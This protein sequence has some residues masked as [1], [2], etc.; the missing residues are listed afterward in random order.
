MKH[1]KKSKIREW[2][3]ITFNAVFALLT[4]SIVIIFYK[5]IMITSVLLLI[6][7]II[8]LLKWKSKLTIIIFIFGAIGGSISEMI[9][10]NY[11]V[12][13]YSII[14]FLNIPFWLI[15]V[16]GNATAFIYQ[17]SLEIKRLGIKK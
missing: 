17:T 1:N 2:K 10:I 14:N 13:N 3:N 12:W 4:I 6:L 16:W 5:N 15:L 7:T 8:G 11:G 9:A